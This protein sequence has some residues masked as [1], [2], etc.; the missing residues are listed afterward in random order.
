MTH[1]PRPA[2]AR[3]LP[4]DLS[5]PVAPELAELLA[6][7]A[8]RDGEAL[9][10]FRTLAHQPKLLKRF[11]LLGGAFLA[12]GLL[13]AREREIV[14]LRVGWNCGSVYEFGQHTLVGRDAGLTDDEIAA[15]GSARALGG[16]SAD[17]EALIALADEICADDCA[18]DATFAAL[19]RRWNDAELVELVALVGFYRMV[20]GFLNTLGVEPE[21]GLPG[22]PSAG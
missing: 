3:L 18:S 9:N 22:W 15:L 5:E 8:I 11:N 14:I 10:I 13:P 4:I 2:S 6:K 7:T 19:R 20:S 1:I 12:H 17:D 16:W 21:D